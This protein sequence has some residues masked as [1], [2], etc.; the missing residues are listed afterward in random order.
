MLKVLANRLSG[1]LGIVI[2]ENQHVFVEGRQIMDAVLVA[3]AVVDDL[4]NSKRDVIL[5]KLDMEKAYDHASWDFVN[6]ILSRLEFGERWR[7]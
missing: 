1:V 4:I 6:Y 3:N 5:C 2:R 7:K